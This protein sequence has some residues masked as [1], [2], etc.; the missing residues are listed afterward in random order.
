MGNK[1]AIL[2]QYDSQYKLYKSFT[3]EVEHQLQ[4]I[5][6][7]EGI[8]CN[9]ITSRLKERES[10]SEKIDRKDDK[11]ASLEEITDIAG[12]RVITYYEEDVD[13]VAEI[14]EQEFAVDKENSI[15]KRKAMEPDRF[16][17]CS[18]HYVIAMSPERLKH[19]ENK[20]Y[21]GLKC[22]IQIRSVLQHAWAEIEHDLGYKS[23]KTIPQKIRRNFSRLA[24]LL[25]IADAE[26]QEI[27]SFLQSYQDEAREKMEDEEL[28]DVAIDAILLQAMIESNQDIVELNE[29]IRSILG[30]PYS[31]T[32]S[33][34]A[35]ETTID[36]LNWFHIVTVSQLKDFIVRNK[37][38]APQIAENFAQDD[39][40]ESI[41]RT[42]AFFY[43][44]Y[45]ELLRENPNSKR[46][47]EYLDEN[48]IDLPDHREETVTFLR[49]INEKLHQQ[50]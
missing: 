34:G 9:A 49:K 32:I 37:E 11:Y 36:R 17:Y 1:T 46:I 48:H 25:E 41:P 44:C 47:K 4:K 16:G 13:R 27:R 42:I 24:G 14:V 18:V 6:E 38:E 33:S 29:K 3:F 26:F 31:D 10:L 28:Q 23:E 45:A 15:D 50:S 2:E 7:V 5:L 19:R 22:E 8:V 30:G 43:L 40:G 12:V 20:N 21:N 35:M 39:E